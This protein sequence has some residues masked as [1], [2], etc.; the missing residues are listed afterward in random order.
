MPGFELDASMALFAPAGTPPDVIAK[1]AANVKRA[2]EQPETKA[3]AEGA[4]IQARYLDPAGL[5]ALVAK[6]TEYWG[7]IIKAKNIAAD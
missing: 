1:L 2:L 5:A 7:K 4:G 3:R 6:D